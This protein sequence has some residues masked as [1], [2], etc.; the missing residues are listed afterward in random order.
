MTEIAK[1]KRLKALRGL[2]SKVVVAAIVKGEKVEEGDTRRR[3]EEK[4]GW[5]KVR[6]GAARRQL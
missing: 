3:E 4:E 2:P 5:K 1:R 6:A